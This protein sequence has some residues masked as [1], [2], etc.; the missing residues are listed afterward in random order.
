MSLRRDGRT[1][2]LIS[3]SRRRSVSFVVV[4]FRFPL[5][6]RREKILR[7]IRQPHKRYITRNSNDNDE[8][9]TNGRARETAGNR[10]RVAAA[11]R[12]PRREQN[13]FLARDT[14]HY[15][16]TWHVG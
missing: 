4:S 5:Y 14:Y 10:P 12:L 2:L 3:S 9:R 15:V 7:V 6:R 13:L 11:A 16:F 1:F 8:T